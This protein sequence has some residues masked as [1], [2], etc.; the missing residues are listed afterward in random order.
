MSF[1]EYRSNMTPYKIHGELNMP[2]KQWVIYLLYQNK[3]VLI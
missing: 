3:E 2:E 1:A